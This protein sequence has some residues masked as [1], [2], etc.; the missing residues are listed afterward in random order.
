MSESTQSDTTP[1]LVVVTGM[2]G[3]GKSSALHALEDIGFESVDNLPVALLHAVVVA[4]DERSIA[5]G[6]DVRTRGFDARH[7][8]SAI[9]ALKQHT[10]LSVQLL[11]MDCDLDVLAQRYT[12]SRRP[13]PLAEDLP[14]ADALELERT[15]LQ[16][17]RANVDLLVDTTHLAPA[18]LKRI[19]Q[20]RFE[21]G[22]H[23]H[24]RIFLMSFAYR[25]GLPR[26][27]DLVLDVRFL[28]NPHYQPDLRP[29]TGL[30]P[31]VGAYIEQD[32][33]AS[34]FLERS[35]ALIDP[36]IPLYE[37]EGKSYLTIAV[38]CTGGKHRS[39]FM[40]ERLKA[41]MAERGYAVE[42]RHRDM[43]PASG[44]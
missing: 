2:S 12:E 26:D 17:L 20:G 33:A 38:G 28:R 23:R 4:G 29:L 19:V 42:V 6:I 39:V 3:A 41:W 9:E 24:M 14:L 21:R 40:V 10:R 22:A 44:S 36:L 27:A 31:G 37:R 30:D 8:M 43:P 1:Q 34:V 16:P 15:L 7:I 11:F 32:P 13:H 35:E 5:V 25:K 18:D